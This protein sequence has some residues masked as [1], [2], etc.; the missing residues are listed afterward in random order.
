MLNIWPVCLYIYFL[1][2]VYNVPFFYHFSYALWSIL[3]IIWPKLKTFSQNP[4]KNVRW[5]FFIFNK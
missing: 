5:V 3:P 1:F 2:C 4:D